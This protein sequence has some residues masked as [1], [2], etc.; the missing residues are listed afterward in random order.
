MMTCWP[1]RAPP[2]NAAKKWPEARA[3][4]RVPGHFFAAVFGGARPGQHVIIINHPNPPGDHPI[5]ISSL[6]KGEPN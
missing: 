5:R 3:S 6:P 2:K 1:G 4:A